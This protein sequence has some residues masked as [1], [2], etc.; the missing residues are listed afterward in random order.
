[1]ATNSSIN[2]TRSQQLNLQL[3][4]IWKCP[5]KHHRTFTWQIFY[6][7]K[8]RKSVNRT[9]AQP[10][11]LIKTD[12]SRLEILPYT[13]HS[14]FHMVTFIERLSGPNQQVPNEMSRDFYLNV[15]SRYP[16]VEIANGPD[17][18]VV[19]PNEV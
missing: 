9:Q 10:I 6:T 5:I 16:V 1:M 15:T 17:A 2:I 18:T 4:I 19:F 8:S 12:S 11:S 3:D 7:G 13:L 14:G